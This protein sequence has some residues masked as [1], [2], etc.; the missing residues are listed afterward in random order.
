MAWLGVMKRVNYLL[1]TDFDLSDLESKSQELIKTVSDK[2]NELDQTAP[3]LGIQDY[4]KKLSEDFTE[5]PFDPLSSV[6]DEKLRRIIDKLDE[7]E[8]QDP[9]TDLDKGR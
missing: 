9:T 4:L 8:E 7:P 3:Q 1:K 6:W 2:M 5:I